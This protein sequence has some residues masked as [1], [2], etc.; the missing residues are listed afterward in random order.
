M[1]NNNF[2]KGNNKNNLD[3][4]LNNTNINNIKYDVNLIRELLKEESEIKIPETS[5]ED[6]LSFYNAQ[7]LDLT[8]KVI[9]SLKQN[10]KEEDYFNSII[11]NL[12]EFKF[13]GSNLLI[14][15]FFKYNTLGKY[16][17]TL[18]LDS[19][20]TQLGLEHQIKLDGFNITI[21]GRENSINILYL[22]Y[23]YLGANLDK[24]QPIISQIKHTKFLRNG[25][26]DVN[27]ENK[28][29]LLI[30]SK[31]NTSG[32][33]F[34]NK[35]DFEKVIEICQDPILESNYIAMYLLSYS[36][37]NL[38]K[39]ELANKYIEKSIS[40]K[41][42]TDNTLL[43]GTLVY[44]L[45]KD[46]NKALYYY[47][48]SLKL[49]RK[50]INS[51]K[52][53]AVL[54]AKKG[55]YYKTI[56]RLKRYLKLSKDNINNDLKVIYS[57]FLHISWFGKPDFIQITDDV[58]KII[59]EKDIKI[60]TDFLKFK[61]KALINLE[62]F[63]D[64]LEIVNQVLKYDKSYYT[65]YLKI[66]VLYKLHHYDEALELLDSILKESQALTFLTSKL[67]ILAK[68]GADIEEFVSLIDKILLV[69]ENSDVENSD[70]VRRV[71]EAIEISKLPDEI[72]SF[73]IFS[74]FDKL[75]KYPQ[76]LYRALSM[77]LKGSSHNQ[78]LINFF[79]KILSGI[80]NTNLISF[81]R[82]DNYDPDPK[83]R[84]LQPNN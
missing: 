46:I 55:D 6:M 29:T 24:N 49:D 78:K 77:S 59:D 1:Y 67:L 18:L 47:N 62:R 50:N 70:D 26:S 39:F 81:R 48:E 13:N 45:E 27:E 69:L 66:G 80:D 5:I 76:L 34:Y 22:L 7:I 4:T 38:G 58:L 15:D 12:K 44:L 63:D 68:S 14:T 2:D 11:E 60:K 83:K 56:S 79:L 65:K 31:I 40:L 37:L 30:L 61:V 52:N 82:P 9:K 73:Y 75:K 35:K 64:A 84:E 3:N 19:L 54:Y 41:K 32:F 74:I 8:N 16:T 20:L 43:K 36:Y 53:S 71:I 10:P 72:K 33:H 57:V 28:K 21:D 51:L 42:T 25:S 23:K 17:T